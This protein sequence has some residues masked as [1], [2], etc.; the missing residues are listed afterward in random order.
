M[1][2]LRALGSGFIGACALNLL[3]ETARQFIPDAPRVDLLGKR[4]IA[5]ASRAVDQEPPSDNELYAL[6][7]AG[8]IVSN[9]LYYSL[10]GLGDGK[11]VLLRGALLGLGAGVGAVALP[12]PIGLG[13]DAS[14]RT[15]ATQAM[16]IAWYT[17]GGLVTAAAY[18]MF[19]DERDRQNEQ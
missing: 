9:S 4:A 2:F 15:P 7:L 8:D 17:F 18:Q 16:T 19:A 5:K 12:G 6:A 13:G 3:H 11:S 14:A 1:K 10:I